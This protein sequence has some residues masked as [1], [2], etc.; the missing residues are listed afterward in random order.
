METPHP[1]N[2]PSLT[3]PFDYATPNVP[4][5]TLLGTVAAVPIVT[6][7]VTLF[8][9]SQTRP[10][11]SLGDKARTTWFTICRVSHAFFLRPV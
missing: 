8:V 4:L 11:A 5:P 2:P 9:L 7:S 10:N 3:L 1:Y 6:T